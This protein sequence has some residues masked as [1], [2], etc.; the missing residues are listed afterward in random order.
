ML[1]CEAMFGSYSITVQHKSIDSDGDESNLTIA[2]ERM[3]SLYS[4]I[5]A[6]SFDL[7]SGC[8][9]DDDGSAAQ[10]FLVATLVSLYRPKVQIIQSEN[11]VHG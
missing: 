6:R 4:E 8:N 10:G 5:W 1:D 2:F 7:S 3:S 11:Y 9:T